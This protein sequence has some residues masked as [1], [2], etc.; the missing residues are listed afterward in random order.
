MDDLCIR[1]YTKLERE[2]DCIASNGCFKTNEEWRK[3]EEKLRKVIGLSTYYKFVI[4]YMRRPEVK[5]ITDLINKICEQMIICDNYYGVLGHMKIKELRI[6]KD[7]MRII[8][9]SIEELEKLG[10]DIMKIDK[11]DKTVKLYI[12]TDICQY[13][14]RMRDI[15]KYICSFEEFIMRKLNF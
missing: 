15:E 1:L 13:T 6:I 12:N 4:N 5:E 9:N 8:I 10:D 7:L 11:L 3:E 2:A 14:R